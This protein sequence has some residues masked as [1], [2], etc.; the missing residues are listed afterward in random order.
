MHRASQ[1]TVMSRPTPYIPDADQGGV[2]AGD[3]ADAG[4]GGAEGDGQPGGGAGYQTDDGVIGAVAGCGE[5]DG[6]GCLGDGK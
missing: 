3:G 2:A 5:A 6:L 4:G 1:I